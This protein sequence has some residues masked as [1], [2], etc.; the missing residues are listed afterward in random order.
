[1]SSSNYRSIKTIACL[2][3][4]GLFTSTSL[5][6]Q[7]ETTAEEV[8][9]EGTG[10]TVDSIETVAAEILDTAVPAEAATEPAEAATTPAE[11]ATEPAETRRSVNR[12]GIDTS[13]EF[14]LDMS[15]PIVMAPAVEPPDV[16][17]PNAAQDA[18]LQDVLVRL[19]LD[20]ED[21]DAVVERN[22][23]LADVI[24][25]ANTAVAA[26]DL[27]M[28]RRMETAVRTVD[29]KQPGLPA[30]VAAIQVKVNQNQGIADAAADVEAGRYFE[31]AGTNA[32]ERYDVMLAADAEDQVATAGMN[33]LL[34]AVIE[35]AKTDA[36]AGN[37][38][39]SLAL[40]TQ[41]EEIPLSA[42]QLTQARAEIAALQADG[43]ATVQASAISSID[44][45]RFEAADSE[46]TQLVALGADPADVTRLRQSLEDARRYGSFTPGQQI[47]DS[48]TGALP[49]QTPIMI[50]IPA[51]EF[52]MGSDASVKDSSKNE[53]P[54]HRVGI[55]RG[56]A[57]A[58]HEI[59]VGEFMLFINDTKYFTDAERL[60]K[61]RIYDEGNGAIVEK[62]KVN[63]RHDFYGEFADSKLPVIHVSWDDATAYAAWLAENT[64]RN[65]S[66]P[67]EAEFEYALRAGSLTE[68]WWGDGVPEEV[69]TNLTGDRD[70]SESGRRWTSGFRRYKDGFW[71]PAPV[72]S[73]SANAF[74]LYDM[75][76][77][78][79]EWVEDCWHS[80]YVQ[81]PADGSAWINPGCN[82]RVIRGGSWSSAPAQARSGSRISAG[83]TSRFSRVGFRVARGL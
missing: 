40:L 69:V 81:A 54:V 30:L 7:E 25:Q 35:T 23:I 65:Y 41:A 39:E 19:A 34:L 59:T 2:I 77:N 68:Y 49:G 47:Q 24:S 83:S 76:G 16:T 74:G 11:A 72:S 3:T 20:P 64:G 45:G 32:F 38:E 4:F 27:A 8:V 22:A 78:I 56:F 44:T 71:G 48:F 80:T 43:I 55:S 10:A 13:N 6:A 12:L 29:S 51:G 66:L 36:T 75:G 1:M 82:R 63:W 58:Q 18:Q 5:L 28:A 26:S 21:L 46:I 17:L 53:R 42:A 33:T 60:G 52:L 61:S 62:E 37:Y 14:S 50:V 67:S 73:F 79:S 15:A 57:M 70:R 31:P 9:A